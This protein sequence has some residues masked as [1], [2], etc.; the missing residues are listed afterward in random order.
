MGREGLLNIIYLKITLP[1]LNNP[2]Y[3]SSEN[4]FR[5]QKSI[6]L[7]KGVH[8]M[9]YLKNWFV[10]F[11]RYHRFKLNMNGLNPRAEIILY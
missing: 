2:L 6:W 11:F 9:G 10:S 7:W 1:E 4:K 3:L 8:A 5:L